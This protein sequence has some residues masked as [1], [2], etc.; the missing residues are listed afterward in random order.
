MN[1]GIFPCLLVITVST[2]LPV[3]CHSLPASE[4][5]RF[6]TK[7]CWL[8]SWNDVFWCFWECS[9][10]VFLSFCLIVSF[11]TVRI[12]CIFLHFRA[13]HIYV[14]CIQNQNLNKR[15]RRQKQTSS[16]LVGG[17]GAIFY[18][19]INIGNVIIPIDFHIFQRGG[20]TTNQF[21]SVNFSANPRTREPLS[22]S[23]AE[24]DRKSIRSPAMATDKKSSKLM[25]KRWLCYLIYLVLLSFCFLPDNNFWGFVIW[26]LLPQHFP[27]VFVSHL[28]FRILPRFL[29]MF[30]F[31]CFGSVF[32]P[33]F[34]FCKLMHI[35]FNSHLIQFNY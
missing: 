20:P 8:C 30:I 33:F 21:S 17:L 9:L 4:L 14:N 34:V 2:K 29:E 3:A 28:A 22:E 10:N 19:P 15:D 35:M 7:Q 26:L 13:C 32:P 31:A 12:N 27:L 24:T 16:S 1:F 18:F 6:I 5:G 11:F 23:Q 25:S